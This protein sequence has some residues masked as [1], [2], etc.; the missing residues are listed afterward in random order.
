VL[1]L[2]L[3]LVV[4]VTMPEGRERSLVKNAAIQ[5]TAGGS[6]GC[7]EVLLMHPLDLIKTRLQLQGL[8]RPGDPA[9]YTGVGDCV[10]KMW[11]QEGIRSFWKGILPPVLVET[12]KRG[13][14]FFTFE[15]FQK[16]FLFGREA[17]SPL[18]FSLAGLAAGVTEA[19]L[20]NPAEVV[21][22][23]LQSNR[24][25]QSQA[26]STWSV[27]RE[28]VRKEGLGREGLLG[29]GI[30]ATMARNGYFNMVY[31]GF[32][33]SVK[34]LVP[35]REDPGLEFLRKVLIGLTAGTLG[36]CVNIPFDVAKSRIQGPQPP[37]VPRY[38]GTARTVARVY[39]EEGFLALYKG[40]VPKIMRLGPGGAIM[41]LVYEAMT[42]YLNTR[43]PD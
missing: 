31:F 39:R 2:L 3:V 6:A 34:G 5:L 15:Q 18:T 9:H 28:I 24:S 17:P 41:L 26:P 29:K 23:S 1:V 38:Q 36:C 37:G 40:L 27:A 25:H 16:V 21:K 4:G 7:V 43:F 14:K 13:W 12:P 22:V 10:R 19:V 30:T 33:H 20:V 32:Y 35:P 42:D 8:A 11:K